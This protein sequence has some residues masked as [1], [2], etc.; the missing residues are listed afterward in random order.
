MEEKGYSYPQSYKSVVRRNLE[1]DLNSLDSLEASCHVQA[2]LDP[3]LFFFFF[4][5]LF[6][7]HQHA[8]PNIFLP[9]P[10]HLPRRKKK[11]R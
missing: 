9:L 4:F 7:H 10:R 6:S 8:K 11:R 1:P 3:I 5:L 2:S